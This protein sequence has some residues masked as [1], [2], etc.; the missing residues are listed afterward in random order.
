MKALRIFVLAL[1]LIVTGPNGQAQTQPGQAIA[2]DGDSLVVG[3]ERVRLHGVDAFE[4]EQTCPGANGGVIPCGGM[5]TRALA[6]LVRGRRV[7]CEQQTIDRYGRSIAICLADGRDLGAAMVQAGLAM[8][9]VRYAHDYVGHE[10]AARA[11]GM[12]V[13]ASGEA[14]TPPWEWRARDRAPIAQASRNQPVTTTTCA[15]RGNINRSGD[16]IYHLP[17]TRW[18]SRTAPEVVFCT[19]EEAEAAGFRPPRG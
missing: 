10:R 12:G 19:V 9:F 6:A 18:W 11:A 13:W 1:G 8:A 17:G 2:T 15:I 14:V 7:V 4:A 3:G 5:A 16:R